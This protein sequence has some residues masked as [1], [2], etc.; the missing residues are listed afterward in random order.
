MTANWYVLHSKANKEDFLC[1]QLLSAG[2]ES[3]CPR[4][5]VP[6]VNPRAR[7]TRPY[8]PGYVFVR[9]DLKNTKTSSLDWLPGATGFVCFDKDPA[10]VPDSL[11]RS[12]RRRVDEIKAAGGE[13]LESLK[14]GETVLIKD[15]PFTGYEAIF[16]CRLSASE[17]VRVLLTLVQKQYMPLE[18]SSG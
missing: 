10:D 11:V 7:K 9:L 15:G 17:R 1:D 3:Y 6:T 12:I 14:P 5:T 4:L 13:L 8:F 16:D 2:W 18:L